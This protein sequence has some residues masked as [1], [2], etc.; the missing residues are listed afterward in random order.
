MTPLNQCLRTIADP[1]LTK[2]R[3]E[4]LWAE[5]EQTYAAS[6][7]LPLTK[8]FKVWIINIKKESKDNIVYWLNSVACTFDTTPTILVDFFGSEAILLRNSLEYLKALKAQ[9]PAT[10]FIE[11]LCAFETEKQLNEN[12]SPAKL[13]KQVILSMHPTA[14]SNRQTRKRARYSQPVPSVEP[15]SAPPSPERSEATEET[16]VTESIPIDPLLTGHAPSTTH[17]TS[18][19]EAPR[20][21]DSMHQS[22]RRQNATPMS[23]GTTGPYRSSPVQDSTI[24]SGPLP[25]RLFDT[26]VGEFNGAST[27]SLDLTSFDTFLESVNTSTPPK[28]KDTGDAGAATENMAPHQLTTQF[29]NKRPLSGERYATPTPKRR[30][31]DSAIR[32]ACTPPLRVTLE[33]LAESW[34]RLGKG[35]LDDRIVNLFICRLASPSVGT[36]DSLVL[37]SHARNRPMLERL[38]PLR[39]KETLLMPFHVA[40]H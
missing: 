21:A 23:P 1:S 40:Q 32:P 9:R 30:R 34:P 2:E 4:E 25:S 7:P 36:V 35:W 26:S 20:E 3:K 17:Q 19:P 33:A 28:R 10:T 18:M 38:I 14:V 39:S 31:Q 6:P 27:S 24:V 29:P 16:D 37:G 8:S 11:V 13:L 22:L 15:D 12:M 5:L